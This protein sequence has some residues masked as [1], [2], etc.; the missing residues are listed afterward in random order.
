MKIF[1]DSTILFSSAAFI[2]LCLI[3]SP[4]FAQ[5]QDPSIQQKGSIETQATPRLYPKG[6]MTPAS[7][8]FEIIGSSSDW[9]D[10]S[11][12][13][14]HD[15]GVRIVNTSS[16]PI[17]AYFRRTYRM[18]LGWSSSVCWGQSCYSPA[19]DSEN[20][21]IAPGDTATLQLNL[22]PALS[23]YPDSSTVW[24][25]AGVVGLPEDTIQLVFRD[26]FIPAAS[27]LIF[28]WAQGSIFQFVFAGTGTH[29]ISDILEN[30]AA[31]NTN[32]HF[33]TQDSIP[34]G[35]S[36]SKY[37]VGN[38]CTSGASDSSVFEGY[39]TISAYQQKINFTLKV[40]VLT[41][42]DS[43]VLYLSVHP[44]TENHADS[45]NY[46]FVAVVNT[47]LLD[48]GS[49]NPN[50]P[51]VNFFT[52]NSST[53]TTQF[54]NLLTIPDSYHFSVSSML[55]KGWTLLNYCVGD[56]CSSGAEVVSP[57][58]ATGGVNA[59][60][61]LAFTV[62]TPALTSPDS[63][64]IYLTSYPLDNPGD[65]RM[66]TLHLIGNPQSNVAANSEETAGLAVTNAWPNPVYGSDKLTLDIL[67]DR[68]GTGLARIY[69][70]NGME[71]ANID[72]GVL[73]FG[74]NEVQ[75]ANP[76]LHSG[77]YIIRVEQANESSEVVRINYIK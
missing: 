26:S 13:A 54:K 38:S 29:F 1:P 45:A 65:L 51:Y 48:G 2:A 12:G 66:D 72:L 33:S 40:P 64:L 16:S 71:Q 23:D 43:V 34:Q 60:Q 52:G 69:D 17:T 67:T 9:T 35:W 25:R 50:F 75:I 56:S 18:P 30:H 58:D 53:I 55:P 46:R 77:E 59:I 21:V 44:Q 76:N 63:C 6:S 62:Q 41:K 15:T 19:D 68:E 39:S 42:K 74:A 7:L 49:S 24:L 28:K 5:Q 11:D 37:C 47:H 20:Y 61:N 22:S 4:G 73:H 8:P 14:T 36:L 3:T 31:A 27:P 57:F 70:I 10:V 32:Y